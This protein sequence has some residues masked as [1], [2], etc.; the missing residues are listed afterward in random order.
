MNGRFFLASKALAGYLDTKSGRRLAVAFFVNKTFLDTPAQTAREG[1]MLGR[2][3]EIV[4][5]EE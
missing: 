2:L 3:C 4:I 1:K 5:E